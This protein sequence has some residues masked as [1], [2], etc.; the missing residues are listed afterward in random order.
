MTGP[1]RSSVVRPLLLL[2]LAAGCTTTAPPPVWLG[3]VAPL[4]GAGAGRSEE[5]VR[6]MQLVLE[7]ARGDG[8][9]PAAGVRHVD[10]ADPTRGQAETVRLLAVNRVAALIAGPGLA[11]P[12]AALLAGRAH[13]APVVLTD[14]VP[15]AAAS[16]GDVLL[17]PDP[18]QRGR[19]LARAAHGRLKRTKAILF[20]DR[21]DRIAA[22]A[23]DAFAAEWRTLGGAIEEREVSQSG[24]ANADLLVVAVTSKAA[25]E[26]FA[27]LAS[28]APADAAFLYAGADDGTFTPPADVKQAVYHASLFAPQAPPSPAMKAWQT[29]YEQRYGARPGRAALLAHDSLTLLLATLTDT[30][31]RD[32]ADLIRTLGDRTTFDSLTGPVVWADGRPQRTLYLLRDRGGKRDLVETIPA[33]EPAK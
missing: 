20:V 14:E 32:R 4:S 7:D 16:P 24:P 11:N 6:A 30:P 17:G 3:H 19:T 10:V 21:S 33:A 13:G 27:A 23:A 22:T 12:E 1:I 5:A 31:S 18:V 26:A 29:R 25:N 2:T 9:L 15:F 28:K 8:E